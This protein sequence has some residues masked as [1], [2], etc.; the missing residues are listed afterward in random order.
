MVPAQPGISDYKT[1]TAEP[2][3]IAGQNVPLNFIS[4]IPEK[5]KVH[6]LPGFAAAYSENDFGNVLEQHYCGANFCIRYH[7]MEIQQVVRLK[8][9]NDGL[10]IHLPV[11]FENK[12]CIEASG[13]EE[14][15]LTP[16]QF[17]LISDRGPVIVKLDPAPEYQ[18]VEAQY[19]NAIVQ[20]LVPSFPALDPFADYVMEGRKMIA[21][22]AVIYQ[23]FRIKDILREILECPFG[24]PTRAF[25]YENKVRELLLEMLLL[26]FKGNN[27]AEKLS[28]SDE[29]AIL[30]AQR[31]IL[32]D[33][34]Q[35]YTIQE[36]ARYADIS[37]FKLKYGFQALFGTGVFELLLDARMQHARNLL[38]ETSIP[39]KEIASIAGYDRV[40]S[41][42]TAF[43]KY[44][45]Y[46]PGSL[47]RPESK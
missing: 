36:I 37:E 24:G 14:L 44:Y 15:T 33:I 29:Q 6:L 17:G 34:S 21:P 31:F 12:L 43:R 41:F 9:S 47:R 39:V 42:I 19:T 40:T 46:T 1:P 10:A 27:R 4:P 18:L 38:I 28:P 11:T 8:T 35:H 32:S 45:A 23:N 16:G 25:F 30:N 26:A 13:G 2:M 5:L 22:G 7:W 20:Q 3:Q